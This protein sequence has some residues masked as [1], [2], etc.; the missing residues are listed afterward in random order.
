LFE[1][2]EYLDENPDSGGPSGL[3]SRT[4]KAADILLKKL[5]SISKR[6]ISLKTSPGLT[7]GRLLSDDF[8][9]L[10]E[11]VVNLEKKVNFLDTKDIPHIMDLGD[12]YF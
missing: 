11:S 8:T 9:D 10:L 4:M 5:S 7:S 2:F 12:V 6:V 3:E 1:K